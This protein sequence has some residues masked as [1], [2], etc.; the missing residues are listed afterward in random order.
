M[1]DKEWN[2]SRSTGQNSATSN[3]RE[4][5]RPQQEELNIH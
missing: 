4:L 5:Q 2:Q 3:Q 1:K